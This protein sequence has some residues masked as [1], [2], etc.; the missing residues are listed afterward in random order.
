MCRFRALT[1]LLAAIVLTSCASASSRRVP[2]AHTA[3]HPR[4]DTLSGLFILQLSN[5]R[6]L[7]FSTENAGAVYTL[8]SASIAL[9]PNGIFTRSVTVTVRQAGET[10]T[11]SRLFHGTFVY[12]ASTHV[13]SPRDGDG[14]SVAGSIMNDTM[15]LQAGRE[16]LVFYRQW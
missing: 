6:E 4:G 8:D 13:V 9:Q 3:T 11:A 1:Y 16:S 2:G 14:A 15:T 5:G 10:F 7:P 12:T